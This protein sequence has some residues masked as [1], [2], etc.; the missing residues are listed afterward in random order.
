MS[1]STSYDF[2]SPF[3]TPSKSK[4]AIIYQEIS[5]LS[6]NQFLQIGQQQEIEE[7]P[8]EEI[9]KVDEMMDLHDT[10]E[11]EDLIHEKSAIFDDEEDIPDSRSTP[12]FTPRKAA[13][14]ARRE[15]QSA[16]VIELTKLV[17]QMKDVSDDAKSTNSKISTILL[18]VVAVVAILFASS[19]RP[20]CNGMFLL[21]ESVW[22]LFLMNLLKMTFWCDFLNTIRILKFNFNM[23]FKIS[24]I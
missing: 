7:I 14:I 17:K 20:Y 21:F 12:S 24:I 13:F 18:I 4:P 22:N 10:D 9:A 15:S 2:G 19:N 16:T 23:F 5:D 1:S 3:K 11:E 8:D 6:F